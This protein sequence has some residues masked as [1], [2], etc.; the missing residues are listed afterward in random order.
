MAGQDIVQNMI[1]TLGQSQDRRFSKALAEHFIDIEERGDADL[2][3]FVKQLSG[4]VMYHPPDGGDKQDWRNFFPY[5]AEQAE[6]WLA[7]L[8]ADTE[9]HL[10]LL[11]AFFEVYRKPKQLLNDLTAAHLE[12]YYNQVLRLERRQAV[13]DRAHLVIGLKNNAP[14]TAI[15]PTHRFSA[16]K[17]ATGVEL[18]YRPRIESIINNA[19]ITTLSS[20]FIDRRDAGTVR[21]APIA[22]S[23][24]GLG[25]ELEKDEPKWRGFGYAELPIAET[26]FALSSPVLRMQEGVRKVS[27]SLNLSN[28]DAGLLNNDKLVKAFNVYISA[29]KSWIGPLTLSPEISGSTLSFEFTLDED[30]PAV[31][32]YDSEVHGY[33]FEAQA[34]LLQVFLNTGQSAAVGY[35][36]FS[37]VRLRKAKL[38]VEVN[39]FRSLLLENDAGKLNPEKAF[40]PFGSQPEAGSRFRIGCPEALDKKLSELKFTIQWKGAPTSFSTHYSGYDANSHG[41]INN[42]YFDAAASFNDAGNLSAL[43]E[44][45]NLFDTSDAAAQ[46]EIEFNST[47]ASTPATS[48]NNAQMVYALSY[49]NSSWAK[50]H[51]FR[52][53]LKSPVLYSASKAKP[54]PEQGFVTLS[55]NKGFEHRN[56]RREHVE[57]LMTYAKDGGTL[58]MLNEP[59]TPEIQGIKMSYQAFTDEIN[60][61]SREEED[62][63]NADLGFYHLGYFGQMREHAFQRALFDFVVDKNVTLM[64]QYGGNGELLLGI[65][66]LQAGD[67][68]SVLFQVAEG[69]ADPQLPTENIVWS[70]L[71][72]NYWKTLGSEELIGDSGNQLLTSGLIRFVIPSEATTTNTLL[73]NDAIW[74]RASI[75]GDV[76]AVCQLVEVAANAI[77]VTFVDQGNDPL[78]L[79]AALPAGSIAKLKTGIA[80]VRS[81]SQPYASIDGKL[82]EGDNLYRTRVAERLRHKDRSLSA[83]DGERLILS[84]FPSIHKVKSIPH[85]SP[86][87]WLAPGHVTVILVADLTNKNAIDP[88]QPRVDSDTIS[89]VRELLKSRSGMQVQY[90]VRNPGYQKIRLNFTVKFKTG[91]EFNYYS[92]QLNAELLQYLSPWAYDSGR[93]ISFGGRIYKSVL[94]DFVEEVDYVD[95]VTDFKLYSYA[96]SDSNLVD[97]A[98][99]LP[100]APDVILVSEAQHIINEYIQG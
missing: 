45:K 33:N 74:L 9:P 60:L 79:A 43:N 87:S 13:P 55:L 98:E 96:E 39:G 62:F 97:V 44:N 2:L 12:F 84:R 61:E 71:C 16:G 29:E 4:H 81:V 95:F 77:E 26:G 68:L 48:Q 49:M 76:R 56:Y 83:W 53:L 89:Q 67:S 80:A 24:D 51:L 15:G 92:K 59:Y 50:N 93:D 63:A 20:I 17:D 6:N 36:S 11:L 3:K 37:A 58:V 8:G 90:H 54:E 82:T 40:L 25:G 18:V 70:V 78:H 46:Q 34:P 7:S 85:S 21:Y 5:E 72:D 38:T 99:V 22:N 1:D 30:D 28:F 100:L 69:S 32:D 86:E 27:V 88:L 10:A 52:T 66:N 65:E 31:V 91:Y 47:S 73:P 41:G 75:A 64:P 14:A 57:N 42:S 19:T 35:E 23:S 94:L